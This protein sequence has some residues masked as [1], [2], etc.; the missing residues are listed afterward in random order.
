MKLRLTL[1]NATGLP[2]TATASIEFGARESLSIGRLPGLDWTLPDPSRLMSGRHCEISRSPEAYLLYDLSTNGTFIDGNTTRL[3]SPH[4]LRDGER[5]RIGAYLIRVE[6]KDDGEPVR[7]DDLADGHSPPAPEPLLQLTIES[8]PTSADQ[9]PLTKT[10]GHQGVLRIG[11]DDSNDWTLPDRTGGISRRH[12]TIR[13][14]DGAFVLQDSS[15]NG[16]FVNHSSERINDRVSDNYPL[17]DGD[18]LLIGPYLIAVQIT[19]LAD[20][21]PD[22][23]TSCG[24]DQP[25]PLP[26][27]DEPPSAQVAPVRPAGNARRGGDPA[28]LLADLPP[29][30]LTPAELGTDRMPANV[31]AADDGMTLLARVVKTPPA[32]PSEP[33]VTRI[34]AE[35]APSPSTDATDPTPPAQAA[36]GGDVLASMARGLGLSPEDLEE[37]DAAALG[38]R[39][40]QLLLL[41][42]DEIRQLQAL[43]NAALDQP[44]GVRPG[45]APS[46]PLSIMPTNEEALRVLFGPPRRAYLDCQ[47]SFQTSLAELGEHF[48]QTEAAVR[49]AVQI[50]AN[51]LAPEAIDRAASAENRM[52]QLLSSRKARLWDL[53][54]ERWGSRQSL[55]PHR[56][57][58]SFIATFAGGTARGDKLEE[59]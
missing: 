27:A 39:L 23:A 16:T 19:G 40:G 28:L 48:R 24:V 8:K 37:T 26:V 45:P 55:Q 4:A 35:A 1:E 44:P 10:L 58:S 36:T 20:T 51:E 18:L 7:H 17:R 52:G 25:A 22:G 38:E 6:I 9:H 49:T 30:A 57:V 34:V 53:Y 56:P 31:P 54:V 5:L 29:V 32:L 12:C 15:S 43:R 41:I 13:F 14:T 42:T 50:M 21:T 47:Q 46:N 59:N 3:T 11:R 2:A 33:V